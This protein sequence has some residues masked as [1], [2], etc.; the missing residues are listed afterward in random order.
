MLIINIVKITSKVR[1]QRQ[2]LLN[3]R[4]MSK[5]VW[6]R[7]LCPMDRKHNLVI[8]SHTLVAL[9]SSTPRTRLHIYLRAIL[10]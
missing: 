4:P 6:A 5:Q 8:L 10:H 7:D 9:Q 3:S 2:D 1:I